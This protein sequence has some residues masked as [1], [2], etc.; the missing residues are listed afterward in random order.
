MSC[1]RL[2][3]KWESGRF[4]ALVTLGLAV[5]HVSEACCLLGINRSWIAD[6]P[7]DLL[8]QATH[9]YYVTGIVLVAGNIVVNNLVKNVYPR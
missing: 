5:A 4:W 2:H 6:L 9:V 7:S 1:S 8:I 3:S